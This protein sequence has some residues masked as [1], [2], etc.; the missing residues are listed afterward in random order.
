VRELQNIIRNAIL[1]SGP[2]I[3]PGDLALPESA[4]QTD[5]E[6][7]DEA[8]RNHLVK[9]LEKVEWNQTRAAEIL[10]LNRTTLQAK[11]KKLNISK[12]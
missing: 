8:T 5:P 6:D 4:T 9:V 11:M 1:F 3:T 7:F 12:P 10:G 2:E